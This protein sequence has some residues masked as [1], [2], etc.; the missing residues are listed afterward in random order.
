M[1]NTLILAGVD[2]NAK[3]F[4]GRRPIEIVESKDR[5]EILK[6]N[7]IYKFPIFLT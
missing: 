2:M 6:V 1:F 5:N 3:D 7:L 4:Y